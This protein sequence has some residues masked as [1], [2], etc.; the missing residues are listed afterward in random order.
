MRTYGTAVAVLLVLGSLPR[1]AA[2][3]LK[4]APPP[5]SD[6]VSI[7]A[8]AQYEAGGLHQFFFGNSY[9]DLWKTPVRVPVL[10]L[11]TFAGGIRPTKLSGGN[12]TKSL[13]FETRNGREW[14]FRSVDKDD[15]SMPPRFEGTVVEDIMRDQISSSHPG[16][17]L[18][19]SRIQDAAGILH[20]NPRLVVM[21]DD[22]A[23]GEYRKTFAGRLGM[24]EEFPNVPESGA[25]GF[26]RAAE[27]INS[28]DLLPLMNRDPETRVSAVAL[29][30]AR[31]VDMLIG[32]WDRHHGQWKWAR[33]AQDP[34]SPWIPI[35]RDRDKAFI[36]YSGLIPGL[37]RMSAKNI[38]TF[39][40]TYP[41][42]TALTW[43]SIAFDRRMLSGLEKP[44]WDSVA[45]ALAA[46][47]TDSVLEHAVRALPPEYASSGPAMAATLKARRDGLEALADRFYRHLNE[48]V[49]LHA[50]D[51][52]D[53]A[54][55][56]LSRDTVLVSL[57]GPAGRQ[58][59]F[60]RHFLAGETREI[61]LYLHEGDDVA[62][63]TGETDRSI[64]LRVIGGN[65]TNA[66]V[67]SAVVGGKRGTVRRYDL[68]TVTGVE[69]VGSD[70]MFDRRPWVRERGRLVPPGRDRGGRMAPILGIAIHGDYGVIPRLGLSQYRYGFGKRPYAR[71]IA[72]AAEYATRV[73]G[74][75]VEA[76]WD[77]RRE[78]SPLHFLATAGLSQLEVI[79]FHGLGNNTAG[80]GD[81]EFF[82]VDQNQWRAQLALGWSLGPKSDLR[83]GPLAKYVTTDDRPGRFI[84]ADRPYGF[85]EFGQ[86]GLRLALHHDVRDQPRNPRKGMLVD[87][88]ADWYPEVWDV[89]SPF[90]SLSASVATYL[91]LPVPLRPILAV[92]GSG[93]KVLGDFP[94]FEAAFIGGG[95]T[96]RSLEAQ[97]YAGDAALA[98]TTELRVPLASFSF[99]LPLDVGVFGLAETGRVWL[100]G[101]SPGGWHGAMG[102]GFWIGVVD[103]T[104][105]LSFSFTNN[106]ERT[107]I[108]IKAGLS[109]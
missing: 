90:G 22:P 1:P 106:Q 92:R 40:E 42:I 41:G 57:I 80:P 33:M 96:V 29:L 83:F 20:P 2:A 61:R 35:A 87:L 75:R 24:I 26:A 89:E 74:W 6:S 104:S 25:P 36:S 63:V 7:A 54:R 66:I 3:Q 78:L 100:E 98:A 43:N 21:P 17:A 109:F 23:L 99:I 72:L 94:Y 85:D 8:G 81:S 27:I 18:V 60:R 46:R 11:A 28:E 9:R 82:E 58:P 14:V 95:G 55:I 19:A 38:V 102:G 65:G 59:Y 45:K 103:P 79:R 4:P 49:D 12:Q 86:A 76:L 68:G 53:Q 101:E 88:A 44:V 64:P 107:G 77:Q 10:D 48:V 31:L 84:A 32:D 62:V 105:A 37:A 39:S 73:Q 50:T 56:E 91:T 108:F 93:R 71:R 97:R 52:A 16:A 15:V 30:N 51:R 34:A 13:R 67:D 47:L 5:E 70:T 69:A